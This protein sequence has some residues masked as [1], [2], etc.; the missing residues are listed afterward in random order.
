M[1]QF[2]RLLDVKEADYAAQAQIYGDRL[3]KA[4]ILQMTDEIIA[5]QIQQK[6]CFTLKNLAVNGNDLIALGIPTGKTIGQILNQLL[7]MVMEG[8]IE[9][10]QSELLLWVKDQMR[11]KENEV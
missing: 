6:D 7:E 8:T 4:E 1:D 10:N 3:H 5:A 9:N 2:L 11:E